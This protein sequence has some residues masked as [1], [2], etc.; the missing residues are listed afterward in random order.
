MTLSK[1]V[2]LRLNVERILFEEVLKLKPEMRQ[3]AHLTNGIESFLQLARMRSQC[4]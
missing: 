1:S 3:P 2:L 4:K